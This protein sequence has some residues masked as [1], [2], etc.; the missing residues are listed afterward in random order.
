MTPQDTLVEK[1]ERRL[2]EDEGVVKELQILVPQL[3][4]AA[5]RLEG[6]VACVAKEVRGI[7]EANIARNGSITRLKENQQDLS[8]DVEQVKQHIDGLPCSE[9][10]TR[11][12]QLREGS[13]ANKEN[14]DKVVDLILDFLKVA[15]GAVITYVVT[16]AIS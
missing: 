11:I 13:E 6:E 10:A 1:L 4:N 2:K 9:M 14:W 5:D 3:S 8:R 15:G 16:N 12:E 7:E